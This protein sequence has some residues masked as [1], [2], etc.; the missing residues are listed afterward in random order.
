MS[1]SQKVNL[2]FSHLILTLSLLCVSLF[3]NYL[4]TFTKEHRGITE[5]H[6][7]LLRQPLRLQS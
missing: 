5:I 1:Q 6:G 4:K 3:N 2:Y 7:G